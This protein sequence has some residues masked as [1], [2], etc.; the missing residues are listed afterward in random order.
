MKRLALLAGIAAGAL[1]TSPASAQWVVACPTCASEMGQMAG[2]VRQAGDMVSQLNQLRSQYLMLSRTYS[3]IA[4]AT[5]VG[6]IA[7]ALGGVTRTYLPEASGTL[8]MVGQGARLF[9]NAGSYQSADRI[10]NSLPR[11]ASTARSAE[12]WTMEMERREMAT[13]N[14][15][16]IAEAGLADMQDRMAQLAAAQA[17]ISAAQDG[18]ELAAVGNLIATSRANLESHSASV[19]SIRLALHAEDRAERQRAEQ[20]EA[21]GAAQWSEASRWAVDALNNGAD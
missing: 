9:G 20:M 12:R 5:D 21:Q 6:G 3:A 16:A 15:K 11:I 7:S 19:D 10:F 1:A 17:H 18:T 13:A 4:H 14:A 2:W 8:S